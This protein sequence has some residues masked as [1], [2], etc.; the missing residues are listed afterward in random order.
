M[1]VRALGDSGGGRAEREGQGGCWY[2]TFGF[3]AA[4]ALFAVLVSVV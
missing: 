2:A 3:A 1:R 4:A